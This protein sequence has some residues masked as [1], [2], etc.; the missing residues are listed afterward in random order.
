MDFVS[1]MT[2]DLRN[3]LLALTV[4][5]AVK[6]VV[7]DHSRRL[8]LWDSGK[9]GTSGGNGDLVTDLPGQPNVA[10][11]H[12]AGYVTVNEAHGR[13][14]FYWFYEASTRADEKPL[15]LW[16]NGGPGCSS[17]GYG[18]T[19]EIG[20]FIVDTHGNGLKHNPYSWN[21]KANMLFLESPI[22]VG[23]SYSNTTSDYNNL[24]DDFTGE[25]YAGK[26]VP[27]LAELIYDMNKDPNSLQ[28]DL[29]G[30]L[31]GNPE[32]SDAED[33]R[34]LVDY[35]W[36]HAVIS[37][38]THK[39]IRESCDFEGNDTWSNNNCTEGVD[40][41]LK[42]YK[43]IDIYS[44]YTSVCIGNSAGSDDRSLPLMILMK[45]TSKTKMIP[46][47]MGGYDPCLDEYAKAFYNRPDVQK[48]LHVSDG[49]QL[50]NWSIC[51]MKI[52]EEWSDSKPSVL[53]IYKKLITAGLRI[54]VYSG[55]TDG[56]VPVLSTRYSLSSLG[57]P[58]T[59]AWRPWYHQKEPLV[60]VSGW[61]QEYE[62]L[63]FATFRGA[64]HAVPCFKPSNSL[65]F[66]SAFLLG[67]APP[68][69]R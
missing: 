10:F 16:L 18:A 54:W 5:L 34:G 30:I 56:R 17:V 6:P 24:G 31:L 20:P 32:T 52:F 13:A 7:C 42:Q 57:L 15:V 41:V 33:W 25:S 39:I 68:S 59:K 51:N 2:V 11:R 14:L 9:K 49:H 66:F 8:E 55:D 12:Y 45:R 48:A 22:G 53:P 58:I 50:K 37:D 40:E 67:E 1:K 35:A 62:G 4:L 64:G 21:T 47:I 46:R 44:I 65:A 61:F 69:A 63:M 29:Q 19:Q 27:E 43:E 36:S 3:T 23:F 26:Y 60:Q 28:I 38:E